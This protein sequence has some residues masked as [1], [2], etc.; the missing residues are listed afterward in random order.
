[1]TT[2]QIWLWV[3]GACL[4]LGL[5]LSISH[6]RSKGE[7]VKGKVTDRYTCDKRYFVTLLTPDGRAETF[8]V[9]DSVWRLQWDTADRYATLTPG[10][11][12]QI[13]VCGWRN[14]YTSTFR[15]VTEVRE[16]P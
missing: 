14:R 15:Q 11:E 7:W 2:K 1:M 6:S 5:V 8:E 12:V 4:L 9:S 3:L 10:K 13:R 16:V